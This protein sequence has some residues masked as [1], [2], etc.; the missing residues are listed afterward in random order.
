MPHG[1]NHPTKHGKGAHEGVLAGSRKKLR[2]RGS[3]KSFSKA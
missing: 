2:K 1:V 3:N